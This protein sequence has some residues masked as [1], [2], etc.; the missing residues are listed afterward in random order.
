MFNLMGHMKGTCLSVKY[1]GF[2]DKDYV[3]YATQIW[4]KPNVRM[5]LRVSETAPQITRTV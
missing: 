4:F 3:I 1:L 2:S 5:F